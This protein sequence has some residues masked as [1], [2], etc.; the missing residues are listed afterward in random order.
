MSSSSLRRTAICVAAAAM[1]LSAAPLAHGD[2]WPSFG[3]DDGRSGFQPVDAG[4]VPVG[5][6]YRNTAAAEQLIKTSIVT[7]AGPPTAS[8]DGARYAFGTNDG[9]VLIRRLADGAAIGPAAGTDIGDDDAFG[10]RSVVPGANGSS[11]SF[12]DTSGPGGL[13]QLLV[14]HNDDSDFGDA[15]P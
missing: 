7:T 1:T 11:V 6:Q 4:G 9:R 13:G 14:A 15:S 2:H 8:A 10:T 12:A 5:F 3:G